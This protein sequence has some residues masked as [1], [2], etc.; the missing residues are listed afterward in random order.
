MQISEKFEREINNTTAAQI[1]K[2]T[3]AL[4]VGNF[5]LANSNSFNTGMKIFKKKEC[6]VL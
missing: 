3:S 4:E 5:V 1:C 6:S 2:R